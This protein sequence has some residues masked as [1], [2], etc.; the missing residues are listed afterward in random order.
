M[1]L[2]A[3]ILSPF[4]IM[5][6]HLMSGQIR[7]DKVASVHLDSGSIGVGV[8]IGTSSWFSV[9]EADTISQASM[10]IS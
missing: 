7:S 9:V 1:F 4:I 3:F 2:N 6:V 5:S 10:F 8:R